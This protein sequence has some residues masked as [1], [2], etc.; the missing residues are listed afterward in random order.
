MGVWEAMKRK[1]IHHLAYRVKKEN[2]SD[3]FPRLTDPPQPPVPEGFRP[4]LRILGKLLS[5]VAWY[6]FISLKA[7]LINY[8]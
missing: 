4:S 6:N 5:C 3:V 2:S 7:F 8:R 1:F